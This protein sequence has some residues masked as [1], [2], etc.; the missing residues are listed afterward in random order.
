MEDFIQGLGLP[1]LRENLEIWVKTHFLVLD[2]AIQAGLIILAFLFGLYPGSLLRSVLQGEE[3]SGNRHGRL[4]SLR[5]H[6]AALTVPI[7][8]FLLLWLIVGFGQ[9]SDLLG[10]GLTRIAMSLTGAWIVIRLAS[11]LIRNALL[12]QS[13]ATMA[14]LIAALVSLGL[15]DAALAVLDSVGMTFGEARITLLSVAR[16]LLVFAALLWLAQ[17]LSSAIERNIHRATSLT[18]SAQLLFAKITKIALIS[19]AVLIAIGGLGIDL[20]ALTIF[21]GALGIGVGFGLQKV[22][23]N[24]FSGL[25]LLMDRSIKP[26]DVIAVGATYGS[27]ASLGAR[28]TAV[29]T[30]DGIEYLIP[31]EELITQRVENWSHSDTALRLRVPVG[32]SYNS[33][34]RQAM[35]LCHRAAAG[36]DRVLDDPPPRVLLQ[37]FG[38]SS[39]DLEI[40]LWIDDPAKGSAN[41]KSAVLLRVWDLLRENGIEIPFPQRELHL[42][43]SDIPLS[44]AS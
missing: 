9:W 6:V 5:G 17:L 37:A 10:H 14:W 16:A 7:I 42:K 33:D 39:I 43:S 36:V 34:V 13:L 4:H 40:R 29:R 38:E 30:R 24:L 15:Y 3:D 28:Y 2:N 31:N 23:S 18:P 19:L 26:N 12:A 8:A 44:P 41:V 22:A 27:V 20:T 32:I 1:G 21:S 35:E 25:L 11:N